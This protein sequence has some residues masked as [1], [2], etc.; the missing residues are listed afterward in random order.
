MRDIRYSLSRGPL[1]DIVSV[2]C[3]EKQTRIKKT[4]KRKSRAC[5]SE[6][7]ADAKHAVF[8]VRRKSYV[9]LFSSVVRAVE[10]V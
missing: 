8:T 2:S 7:A 9:L 6:F 1:L 3:N 5:T 4:F 10:P